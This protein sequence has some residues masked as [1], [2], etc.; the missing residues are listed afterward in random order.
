M[1]FPVLLWSLVIFASFWGYGE[2]L[3]RALKRPEFD[4]LGWGLTAAWGM[5][6]TLAIGGFLMMFSLAKA[7]MLT[8][9]VLAGAALALYFAAQ[10]LASG[11]TP[12]PASK[13][14]KSKRK[15]GLHGKLDR[16]NRKIHVIKYPTTSLDTFSAWIFLFYSDFPVRFSM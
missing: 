8:G 1:Y 11:T 6:A 5:A 10:R 9:V 16:E 3:R 14:S 2:V 15:L 13:K 4:D 12:Q 7:P